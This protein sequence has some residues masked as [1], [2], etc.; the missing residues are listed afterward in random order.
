MS[1]AEARRL[2]QLFADAWNAH[3]VDA[4]LAMVTEDCVFDASAGG[5][6]YGAR[7]AGHVALREAFAS[8]W[9]AIPDA[10]WDDC[11]HI[12][13][14]DNRGFSEWTFRGTRRSDGEKV[15][16]RGVDLFL[17]RDGKIAYKDTY[18]KNVTTR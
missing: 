11:R 12:A 4:L 9:V 8:I 14:G 16:A 3:D 1:E 6:P 15:E 17:F 5:L 18:R 2:M 13:A 7:H 10:Q